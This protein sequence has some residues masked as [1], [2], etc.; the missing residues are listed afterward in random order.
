MSRR[1][2]ISF[3]LVALLV[4]P[5]C[6]LVGTSTGAGDIA[7]GNLATPTPALA[8]GGGD[9]A[10]PGEYDIEL[11]LTYLLVPTVGTE[12]PVTFSTVIPISPA[13]SAASRA[14]SGEGDILEDVTFT[15]GPVV[16]HNVADWIITVDAELDPAAGAEPLSLHFTFNGRGFGSVEE[17]QVGAH[18]DTGGDT[19]E[20][21]LSL[22]LQEGATKSFDVEGWTDILEWTVVLHLK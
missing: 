1:L 5:A 8:V 7:G 14:G 15:I 18:M 10:P 19:Y 17:V 11:E 3:T 9:I 2:L 20:H 12:E 22:S 6:S 13:L 16:A 21:T 4:V